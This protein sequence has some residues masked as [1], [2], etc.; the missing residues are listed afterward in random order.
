ML[1]WRSVAPSLQK[2][3]KEGS[4]A[5]KKLT[6]S[7]DACVQVMSFDTLADIAVVKIE[8][9]TPLPFVKLGKTRLFSLLAQGRPRLV[10][11]V[12]PREFFSYLG[13]I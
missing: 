8:S 3:L 12:P 9:S 1:Q 2:K 10:E 6:K 11:N 13:L 5:R 7:W 4:P